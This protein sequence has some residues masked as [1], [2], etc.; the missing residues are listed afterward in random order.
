MFKNGQKKCFTSLMPAQ[1]IQVAPFQRIL[2]S[3]ISLFCEYF[4]S[5]FI[6]EKS[7]ITV[8]VKLLTSPYVNNNIV[9]KEKD[10]EVSTCYSQ[11]AFDGGNVTE[12]NI[13]S[14]V[15]IKVANQKE[16]IWNN[17]TPYSKLP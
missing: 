9:D 16:F 4:T 8:S 7:D 17:G 1:I 3:S 12:Q 10:R 6:E 14:T 2:V 15:V 5:K 13:N 11:V